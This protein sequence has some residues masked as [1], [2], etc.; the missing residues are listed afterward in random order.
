LLIIF[1]EIHREYLEIVCRNIK[2]HIINLEDIC[3]N[4]TLFQGQEGVI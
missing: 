1:I 4:M 2:G 3:K